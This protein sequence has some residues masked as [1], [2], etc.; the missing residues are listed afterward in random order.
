MA[1][2]QQDYDPIDG[3]SIYLRVSSG[4]YP[5]RQSHKNPSQRPE[6]FND[7]GYSESN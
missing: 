4:N 3:P 2:Y 5:E 1:S 6:S 7:G